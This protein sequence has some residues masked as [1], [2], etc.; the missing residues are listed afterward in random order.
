LWQPGSKVEVSVKGGRL[1]ASSATQDIGTGARTVIANTVAHEF[2][3]EPHEVEVRIGDSKLP[4]GPGSGG[5]RVT[6]SVIPPTLLAVQKLKVAIESAAK[7]AP[8]KGSNAPGR[9]LLA[10]SSDLSVP[11]VRA[12][13]E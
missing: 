8:V 3:L 11:A 1:I 6:A 5:S 9:E 12:E 13:E 10:P 7:R 2:G 4:E